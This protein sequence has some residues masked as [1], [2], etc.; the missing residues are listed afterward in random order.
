[1]AVPWTPKLEVQV[2]LAGVEREE[3]TDGS[4]VQRP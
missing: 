1:M 2:R 3:H 4:A